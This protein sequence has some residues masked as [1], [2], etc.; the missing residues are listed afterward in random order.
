MQ[1][2]ESNEHP[3]TRDLLIE[4][5]KSQCPRDL[6]GNIDPGLTEGLS[7]A[8]PLRPFDGLRTTK[9]LALILLTSSCQAQ[10]LL[11]E[12]QA[13]LKPK[14]ARSVALLLDSLLI[15]TNAAF[16]LDGATE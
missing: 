5:L 12:L 2:D 14:Q 11:Y 10:K 9:Q 16:E 1:N 3:L 6:R 13:S 7:E 8:S 15:L 4:R